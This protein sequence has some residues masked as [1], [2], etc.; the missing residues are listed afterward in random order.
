[1]T[2]LLALALAAASLAACNS[3]TAPG[4][5]TGAELD[6]PAEPSP[7]MSASEALS[8]VATEVLQPEIMN[9]ADIVSLGGLTRRCIFRMTRVDFPTLL[10]GGREGDATIKLNG[11]LITLPSAGDGLYR[12][13][14]LSV[15]LRR[16]EGESDELQMA[17]MIVMLPGARDELGFRGFADCG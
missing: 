5:D 7:Q 14:G 9:E 3:N 6:P 17:E 1:M 16:P 15:L 2:R 8:G 12:D 4:N 11:K 10:F 13:G